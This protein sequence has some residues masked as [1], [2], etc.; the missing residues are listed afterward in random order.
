MP[1]RLNSTD[2]SRRHWRCVLSIG[3]TTG[4]KDLSSDRRRCQGKNVKD[5]RGSWHG[6]TRGRRGPWAYPRRSV[7]YELLYQIYG[8]ENSL[9]NI[10]YIL[11]FWAAKIPLQF[12]TPWINDVRCLRTLVNHPRL[13][14]RISGLKPGTIEAVAPPLPFP[15][16]ML[17]HPTRQKSLTHWLTWKLEARFQLSNRKHCTRTFNVI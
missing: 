3:V 14:S 12:A 1:T 10:S 4:S 13:R 5:V 16:A 8:S 15:V 17:M 9:I 2:A 7:G 11:P 6:R